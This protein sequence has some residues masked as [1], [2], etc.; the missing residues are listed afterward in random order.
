[1]VI[2]LRV[3]LTK[4]LCGTKNKPA[5]QLLLVQEMQEV[6]T[7]YLAP[8]LKYTAGFITRDNLT[9][10]GFIMLT[11]NPITLPIKLS[12]IPVYAVTHPITTYKLVKNVTTRLWS[13]GASCMSYF[14]S[15]KESPAIT[16]EWVEISREVHLPE[17]V[18]DSTK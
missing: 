9:R 2:T 14:T 4:I 18:D 6:L 7:T 10:A 17:Q 13:L 11:S 8:T 5:R 3:L 16:S 1:L 15:S 12:Y